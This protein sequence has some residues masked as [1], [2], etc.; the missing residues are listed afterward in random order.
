MRFLTAVNITWAYRYPWQ[1][2]ALVKTFERFPSQIRLAALLYGH[3]GTDFCSQA[4]VFGLLYWTRP[5]WHH[6]SVGVAEEGE[7]RLLGLSRLEQKKGDAHFWMKSWANYSQLSWAAVRSCKRNATWPF[8]GTGNVIGFEAT[9]NGIYQ[10]FSP[11]WDLFGT[12][13]LAAS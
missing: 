4:L 1:L 7:R 12:Y 9:D 10:P 2:N 13:K 6:H 11:A 3:M 5:Q 8:L